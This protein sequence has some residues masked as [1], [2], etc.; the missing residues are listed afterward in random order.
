MET[1]KHIFRVDR[2]EM[3]YLRVT[4]ESYDGM[5]VVR[6]IDPRAG[7]IEIQIA[8]LCE[9]LVFDLLNSL[10]EEEGIRLDKIVDTG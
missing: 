2:R 3:N 7:L 4:I 9:N 10:R 1:I 5:A 8:P 6:T